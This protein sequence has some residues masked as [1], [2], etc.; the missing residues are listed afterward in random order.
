MMN[1]DTIKQLRTLCIELVKENSSERTTELID[2]ISSYSYG[3]SDESSNYI[4]HQ[5]F[6]YRCLTGIDDSKMDD[7]E[8]LTLELSESH[9]AVHYEYSIDEQCPYSKRIDDSDNDSES[10]QE[11]EEVKSHCTHCPYGVKAT[12]PL[13]QPRS[14]SLVD[15]D[16]DLEKR[17]MNSEVNLLPAGDESARW[18]IEPAIDGDLF[19]EI[20]CHLFDKITPEEVQEVVDNTLERAVAK[21]SGAIPPPGVVLAKLDLD[22]VRKVTVE[23]D[24]LVDDYATY[25]ARESKGE[26]TRLE[27]HSYTVIIEPAVNGIPLHIPCKVAPH[28]QDKIDKYINETIKKYR[29]KREK[30][31][32]SKNC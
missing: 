19:D 9:K 1:Q 12:V 8:R 17:A 14:I 32:S 2:D 24:M 4:K 31:Q 18:I 28:N 16:N 6:T 21:Q 26:I 22:T 5:F 23:G 13:S 10:S 25:R 3:I 7:I 27:Y 20:E 15:Y 30:Y 29:L 11:G